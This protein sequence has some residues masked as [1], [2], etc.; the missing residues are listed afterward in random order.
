MLTSRYE[1]SECLSVNCRFN[2]GI[3]GPDEMSDD[4]QQIAASIGVNTVDALQVRKQYPARRLNGWELKPYAILNCPYREVLLL[5]ADN[6]ALRNPEALFELPEYA[7]TGA[8][9][10][11]GLW[12]IESRLWHLGGNRRRLSRRTRV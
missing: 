8:I 2:S 12:S 1:F 10:W 9:F 11:P 3:L 7:K 4:M 6:I 5:D